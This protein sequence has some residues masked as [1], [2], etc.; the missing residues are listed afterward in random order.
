MSSIDDIGGDSEDVLAAP[1]TK[2]LALRGA[3][4]YKT[5]YNPEWA[6]EFP[7]SGVNG[8]KHAF[9]CI[10]CKKT[11]QCEH[12]GV[13]DVKQHC[14]AS[15]HKKNGRSFKVVKISMFLCSH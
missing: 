5:A 15:V 11:V 2:K 13:G 7:I 6:K 4:T 1:P 10:P 12:M 3:A 9:Y 8:N 14:K